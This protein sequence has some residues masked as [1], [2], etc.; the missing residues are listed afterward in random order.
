MTRAIHPADALELSLAGIVTADGADGLLATVASLRAASGALAAPPGLRA[1]RGAL[2]SAVEPATSGRHPASLSRRL[3]ATLMAATLAVVGTLSFVGASIG[4]SWL[5]EVMPGTPA[6]Y[7]SPGA[8]ETD[9]LPVQSP[10]PTTAPT[11][12]AAGM[13]VPD[14]ADAPDQPVRW[15]PSELEWDEDDE[16]PDDEEDEDEGGTEGDDPEANEPAEADASDD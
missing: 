15:M 12:E 1:R 6:P 13:T 3:Q 14:L 7:G 11:P 10:T 8:A 5:R 4:I 9:L 2:L 16:S